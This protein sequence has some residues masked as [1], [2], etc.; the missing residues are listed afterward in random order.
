MMRMNDSE[1]IITDFADKLLDISSI[2]KP[3]KIEGRN[4][5]IILTSKK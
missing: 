5:S 3:A 1:H 4:M 2:E